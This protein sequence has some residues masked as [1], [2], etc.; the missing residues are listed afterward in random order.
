MN[1]ESGG[2]SS[3]PLWETCFFSCVSFKFRAVEVVDVFSAAQKKGDRPYQALAPQRGRGEREGERKMD[4]WREWRSG[5]V[6][7][8]TQA[9]KAAGDWKQQ[10]YIFFNKIKNKWY[11][12]KVLVAVGICRNSTYAALPRGISE[13]LSRTQC[14][15]Q[16]I[17][18]ML[19]VNKCLFLCCDSSKRMWKKLESGIIWW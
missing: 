5:G 4:R 15:V 1:A 6:G 17:Y 14:H 3:G 2:K 19:E 7:V 10:E 12:N 16:H 18:G 8:K 9:V 11:L 13:R